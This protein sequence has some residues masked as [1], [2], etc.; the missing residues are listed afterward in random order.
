M[1]DNFDANIYSQNGLVYSCPCDS[2]D[3]G[4]AG[5]GANIRAANNH[6]LKT[7]EMKEDILLDI[8]VQRYGPQKPDMPV[9]KS[10]HPPLALRIFASQQISI[11]RAQYM[12]YSFM[13]SV[14]CEP[15]IPEFNGFNMGHSREQSHLYQPRSS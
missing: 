8:P 9:E 10:T 2:D 4:A 11:Q 12:D 6:C 3:P 14:V 15:N 5:P 13:Q 1:A 7:S